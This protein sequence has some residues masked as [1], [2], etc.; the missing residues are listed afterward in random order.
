MLVRGLEL[1]LGFRTLV[2]GGAPFGRVCRVLH[3]YKLRELLAGVVLP[4]QLV[5]ARG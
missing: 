4:L 5:D 3:K 2:I 1:A